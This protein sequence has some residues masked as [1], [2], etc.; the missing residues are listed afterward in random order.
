MPSAAPRSSGTYKSATVAAPHACTAS[1]PAPASI[2]STM[3]ADMDGATA[4]PTENAKN[5]ENDTMY[6]GRRPWRSLKLDHHM[7]KTPSDNKKMPTSTL[8]IVSEVWS[9]RAT[10][11]TAG[12]MIDVPMGPVVPAQAT[13][14]TSKS[15]WYGP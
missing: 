2:R 9:S 11:S 8:T 3:S 1:A 15:F 10:S 4:D 14:K 5:H 12:K 6:T 13:T 7:G